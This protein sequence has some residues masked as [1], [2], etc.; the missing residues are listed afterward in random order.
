MPTINFTKMHALGNDFIV[1]DALEQSVNLAKEDI[2]KICNRRHG[3]GCDQ[4]LITEK[5]TSHIDFVYKIF[6]ND[7]EEV[8]QCANGARCV[9]NYLYDT[10]QIA[11]PTITLTTL[12]CQIEGGVKNKLPYLNIT[13]ISINP[14]DLP[15][16]SPTSSTNTYCLEHSTLKALIYFSIAWVGNPHVIIEVNKPEL[17]KDNEP[18]LAKIATFFQSSSLFPNSANINFFNKI[19]EHHI[20][21]KTYERGCG[22][23]PSCGSGALGTVISQIMKENLKSSVRVEME[24]GSLNIEFDGIKATLSGPVTNVFSGTIKV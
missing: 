8:G 3:I 4:V 11:S 20:L 23:T 15:F 22:F 12:S 16:L 2:I 17:E 5:G 10:Y 6:N 1:I 9:I 19:N 14:K 18:N 21:L 13:Q 24:S 7:G